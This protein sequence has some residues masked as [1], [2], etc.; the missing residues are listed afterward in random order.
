MYQ[1]LFLAG[2]ER[3]VEIILEPVVAEGCFP[4]VASMEKEVW[5]ETPATAAH[6]NI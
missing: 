3:L 4:V 1:L 2:K 6:M 5:L